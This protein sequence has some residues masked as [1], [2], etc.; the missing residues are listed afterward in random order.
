MMAYAS[1]VAIALAANSTAVLGAL[2]AYYTQVPVASA[3]NEL[4]K[5]PDI[6][7][8]TG[9]D[10]QL[11]FTRAMAYMPVWRTQA[12]TYNINALV[13]REPDP[14][15][16]YTQVRLLRNDPHKVVVQLRYYESISTLTN[17][18]KALDPLVLYGI[19][20][21]VLETFTIND[22]NT[23]DRTVKRAMGT[24]YE[25][26]I[27]PALATTQTMTLLDN[28]IKYGKVH[29]G[30]T[31]PILPRPAVRGNPVKKVPGN[32]PAPVKE[33]TFDEGLTPNNDFVTES[34]NG[35]ECAI[36][37]LM[38]EYFPGVSGT[39]LGFD[40]YYTG[41]CLPA[42]DRPFITNA[43]SA[44]AWVSLDNYPYNVVP[45]VH[46]S[47]NSGAAGWYLG[48]DAYGKPFFKINGISA[49]SPDSL[50]V[51][52]WTHIVGTYDGSTIRLY[53]DAIQKATAA[54]VGA[55]NA[56]NVDLLI[57]RNN[58]ALRNTDPVR[59][60]RNNLQFI[61]G[62]E[63]LIDQICIYDVSLT[64]RQIASL[65][66]ALA[67]SDPVSPI[68][69]GV[70]PG[71]AG[72]G[73]R[74]GA[75]YTT[76]QYQPLWDKMWR[77]DSPDILIKFDHQPTSI[78]FWRGLNYSPALVSENNIWFNDQS[79][80][81][82]L[83]HGCAEHM[84]D[85]QR[86]EC[87]AQIIENTSARVVVH[88]HYA[89]LDIAYDQGPLVDEYYTIY[90][91][92]TMVRYI[93]N[94]PNSF[95]D[96]QLLLSPGQNPLDVMSLQANTL[97]DLSGNTQVLTWT[98][99]VGI[100]SVTLKDA[101]VELLNT[102]ASYKPFLMFTGGTISTWGGREESPYSGLP[103]AGPW[104]HYPISLDPSDGRNAADNTRVRHFAGFGANDFTP[105]YVLYGLTTNSISDLLDL[106]KM[107]NAPP[108]VSAVRGATSSGFLKN[109][110]SFRFTA[111]SS[112]IIFSIDASTDNPLVNPCFV[113]KNWGSRTS[114]AKLAVNGLSTRT[115]P[116][117]DQGIITDT[118]GTYTMVIWLALNSTSKQKFEIS[119]AMPNYINQNESAQ[120]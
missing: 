43:M 85:K 50:A 55:I 73:S 62:M 2:S 109:D 56:P 82:S 26:W 1:A 76:L 17:A 61:Y 8:K 5:Y 87:F 31:P 4:E 86:R 94:P 25:D 18:I 32:L 13:T 116:N 98:L 27:N 77:D 81:G 90:P 47:T 108:P 41:V 58:D 102:R 64:T 104:N 70:L 115:S 53:V 42:T 44:E 16:Y 14:H 33:W 99:P 78:I 52:R 112:T 84:A 29:W 119:G 101:K 97:M 107:F 120:N 110:Q 117:F 80:E 6:V 36:S 92:G 93:V 69:S 106:A 40:G 60:H 46:N 3:G 79:C 83:P 12:G 49:K 19:T 113:I 72:K 35:T 48:V 59:K 63:G 38:T 23:I 22:N 118:D 103:F 11:E 28:G 10:R 24:R 91:D 95:Q 37:G 39:A 57:G 34:V 68:N 89:E 96:T 66:H 88:W 114:A 105:P 111:S 67:P 100:P 75:S 45:F 15:F 9:E 65:Y 71:D 74:F 20:G 7:I 30:A 21:T 51:N 54:Q